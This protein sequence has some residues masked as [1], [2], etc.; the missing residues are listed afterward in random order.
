MAIRCTYAWRHFKVGD[1]YAPAS[2]VEERQLLAMRWY[3]RPFWEPA[4]TPQP[5]QNHAPAKRRKHSE[6]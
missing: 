4:N 6:K 1:E 3:G 5:V 2:E